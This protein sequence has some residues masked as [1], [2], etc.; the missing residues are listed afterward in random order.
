MFSDKNQWGWL[1][2]VINQKVYAQIPQY[3]ELETLEIKGEKVN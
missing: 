2:Y 3:L 1:Y